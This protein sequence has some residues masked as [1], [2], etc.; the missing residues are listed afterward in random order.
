MS[1]Q[2]RLKVMRWMSVVGVSTSAMCSA[3][4]QNTYI[5][6]RSSVRAQDARSA[7]K[8]RAPI[9]VSVINLSGQR[10]Q[11]IVG[12][13]RIELPVG[14]AIGLEWTPGDTLHV[15]SDTDSRVNEQVRVSQADAAQVIAIR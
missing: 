14:Q 9:H 15:M 12:K 2:S 10:R 7:A 6:A 11:A 8:A 4:A 13:Q 1:V 5:V 3:G